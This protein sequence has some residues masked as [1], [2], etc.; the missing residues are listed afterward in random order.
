MIF[1]DIE[2]L[3]Q[4]ATETKMIEQRD[5]RYVRNRVLDLLEID[6]LPTSVKQ[7]ADDSIPAIL[8]R[9]IAYAVNNQIIEDVFDAKEILAADIM[10]C[11]IYHPSIINHLFHKKYEQSPKAATTYFYDLSKNSNYIQMD[12]IKKNIQY[13]TNTKHGNLDITINM[14][15]PE[16]DPEQLKREREQK[17]DIHYPRCVLCIENE[18]YAGR[19]GYPARANHR[20]I[21]IPLLGENWYFQYSPYVYYREHSI[22]ISEKHRDMKINKDTFARLL[23]FIE[24]FPHYFIG[25]NADLP[26]VGGSIL[27]HDHY[28]A[29]RYDFPMTF[30]KN[31]ISFALHSFPN[32]TAG[33][34]EWPLTTI[35]LQSKDVAQ[36]MEAA[37]HVRETW[38]QY[39]DNSAHIHAYSGDTPHNTITPIARMRDE[40]FE[41][42]LVLRNNRTNSTHPLGI[43]HPHADVHHIKKENIGL[44]EV[45]GLAVLPARLK[46]ELAEIKKFLLQQENDIALY[47]QAWAQQIYQEHENVSET[48]VD[49]VMQKEV[50]KK[51]AKG[52]EDAGVFKDQQ[53]CERFIQSLNSPPLT[54]GKHFR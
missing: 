47:H 2:G 23:A 15:K 12:R 49:H 18:G 26:I 9:I 8:K 46:D 40:T 53:V 24:K 30:A 7:I 37:E 20:V 27:S 11:F 50:G 32:V 43:F 5:Q 48:E 16:K 1:R 44:I 42:D 54:Q 28:Q 21:Q 41:L 13:K 35:R 39:S 6:A 38:Q 34:L 36:L 3:V 17:Q 4:K 14:S 31:A 25:S 51:F 22:L 19:T 33:I 29:G 52:L 10:N 45:M